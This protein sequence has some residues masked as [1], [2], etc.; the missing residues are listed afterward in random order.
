[1]EKSSNS[2]PT[3]VGQYKARASP[4]T[5]RTRTGASK[6][7]QFPPDANGH[8]SPNKPLATGHHAIYF[9]AVKC[10]QRNLRFQSEG[11]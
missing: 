9:P 3:K 8:F 7:V 11:V 5:P 2:G 1:M 10:E 4:R 6:S